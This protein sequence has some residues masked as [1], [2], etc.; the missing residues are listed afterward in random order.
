M[1]PRLLPVTQFAVCWSQFPRSLSC[2]QTD[3]YVRPVA[4][5]KL[6]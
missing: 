3:N 4:M 2:D 6:G 1:K 5:V